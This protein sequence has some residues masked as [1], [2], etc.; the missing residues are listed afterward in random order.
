M[1]TSIDTQA[2]SGDGRRS[3]PM[4]RREL[5][6]GAVVLGA[7]AWLVPDWIVPAEACILQQAAADPVAAMRAQIGAVPIE[8]V[9]LTDNL[10]MLSGP[11]GNVLVL[12]GADGKIVVD[13][14]VQPA[15]AG[16]KQELDGFGS[17]P[18]QTLIDTHWHIDHSDNN[19]NFRK[20]GAAILAHENTRKRLTE[21][22]Q[23]LGMTFKPAPPD[24]LP[25]R[26]FKDTHTLTANG[27]Q[28]ALGHIPPAHTDT[29]IYIRCSKANVLHLGDVFFN[30]IYPFIDASTGG[31]VSGMIAGADMALTLADGTT[32]II[33]GHGPLATKADLTSYRDMLVTV[34][35]RVLTLK[36][37]G[38]TLEE[39]VAAAPTK[40]LDATWGK[41]FMQPS[42]FVTLIYTML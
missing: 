34:R 18:I 17:G 27:E 33:P 25:T 39:V 19:A 31:S 1:T 13:G 12:H 29:D 5:L 4:T 41:G 2:L 21:T 38:K 35:D 10:T 14:F 16:L 30:G 28:V 36:K 15:W 7:G 20:A 22:H 23:L 24:A 9:K 37:S 3:T 8:R 42:N 32:K 26:T 40:D 11:G 6:R